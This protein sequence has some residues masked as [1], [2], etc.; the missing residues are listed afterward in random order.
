M[1]A[2]SLTAIA[3][4]GERFTD[5]LLE[6]MISENAA[7]LQGAN[8]GY[9]QRSWTPLPVSRKPVAN[10]R[11]VLENVLK[12]SGGEVGGKEAE[13]LCPSLRPEYVVA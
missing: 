1:S 10:W 4:I 12:Q 11:F 2:A 13:R 5:D 8:S 7:A 9:S 6:Y 3:R